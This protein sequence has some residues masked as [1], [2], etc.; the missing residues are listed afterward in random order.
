M[1]P[2]TVFS[3]LLVLWCVAH[4]LLA[5]DRCKQGLQHFFGK[6]CRYYRLVYN[7]FSLAT[8]L[9]ILF[10]GWLMPGTTILAWD[11]P[12]RLLKTLLWAIAAVFFWGGCRSYDLS[13]FAGLDRFRERSGQG[14]DSRELATGGMLGIV[15]H[16]WYTGA[17]I[18]L[19]ARD[20]DLPAFVVSSV[21][22]LYLLVGA[23]LEEKRLLGEFG[24]A[25]HNY[26]DRVP[27]FVPWKW[28]GRLLARKK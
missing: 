9:P 25:Y 27:M 21:F 19:W 26:Q 7:L 24:Q 15:R 8:L 16:P 3:V 11:G 13:E 4:S 18:V 23:A 2:L 10:W 17:F 22:T 14:K 12:W 1:L 6:Q 28:L 5:A 20:L